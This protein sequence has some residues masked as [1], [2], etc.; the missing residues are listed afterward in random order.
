MKNIFF[1]RTLFL[2]VMEI[3]ILLCLIYRCCSSK[4]YSTFEHEDT[5]FAHLW[6]PE[7]C[8]AHFCTGLR[9]LKSKGLSAIFDSCA[10]GMYLYRDSKK[11]KTKNISIIEQ[12]HCIPS[13]TLWLWLYIFFNPCTFILKS[14]GKDGNWLQQALLSTGL[15]KVFVH[16]IC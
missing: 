13:S 8:R 7:K 10:W 2:F 12:I 4:R 14:V 9:Q 11:Y 16:E 3:N 6:C 15:R 1:C 5:V